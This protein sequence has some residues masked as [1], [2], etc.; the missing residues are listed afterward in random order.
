MTKL[1]VNGNTMNHDFKYGNSI[2]LDDLGSEKERKKT[3]TKNRGI[4]EK[5]IGNRE[6]E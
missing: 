2:L 5:L 4:K 1:I 3:Q 6:R